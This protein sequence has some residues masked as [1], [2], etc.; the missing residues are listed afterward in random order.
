MMYVILLLSNVV[1]IT[2]FVMMTKKSLK[3]IEKMDEIGAQIEESLDILDDCYGDV[4]KHLKSPVLFDDPVV[5]T[6]VNDVKRARDA[7]LLVA[8]KLTEPFP[9][10]ESGSD[11]AGKK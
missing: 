1:F 4:S 9:F 5:I 3:L 7:M 11:E 2:M 8:N 6:M 10:E